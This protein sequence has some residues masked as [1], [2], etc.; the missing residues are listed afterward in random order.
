[1]FRTPGGVRERATWTWEG[2]RSLN[3]T[4][5]YLSKLFKQYHRPTDKTAMIRLSPAS[6]I[7]DVSA[8]WE[9]DARNRRWWW[10]F[11]WPLWRF[12]KQRV[13][14]HRSLW[15]G[16]CSGGLKNQTTMQTG[17]IKFSW[18]TKFSRKKAHLGIKGS[19]ALCSYKC[20]TNNA[21]WKRQRVSRGVL[22]CQTFC[23]FVKG[24]S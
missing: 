16:T 3:P 15:G 9:R 5:F 13:R 2:V 20:Q 8:Q 4:L 17:M 12:R 7:I 10:L 24:V 18:M 6:W 23:M 22:D 19:L 11:L 1:M 21:I 14:P